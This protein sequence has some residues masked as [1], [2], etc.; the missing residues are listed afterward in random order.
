MRAVA[1]IRRYEAN[2]SH[3]NTGHLILTGASEHD[4][5][6]LGAVFGEADGEA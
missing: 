2:L 5:A 1:S 4:A 3:L 6:V